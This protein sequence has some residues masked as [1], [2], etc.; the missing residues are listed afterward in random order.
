MLLDERIDTELYEKL[1]KFR[2]DMADRKG[3]PAYV[4][5]TDMTLRNIAIA[6]PRNIF[7]LMNVNGIGADK[8]EKYGT[9][10]INIVKG[11]G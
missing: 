11:M 9:A 7:E 8:A 4:I 3:V 1:R 6:K 5:F 2:R 10:V